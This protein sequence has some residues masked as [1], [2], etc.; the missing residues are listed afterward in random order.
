MIL[1]VWRRR[2]IASSRSSEG[3]YL[4]FIDGL[5]TSNKLTINFNMSLEHRIL[6]THGNCISR[7]TLYPRG[8]AF[9]LINTILNDICIDRSAIN[10][11]TLPHFDHCAESRNSIAQCGGFLRREFLLECIRYEKNLAHNCKSI[12][13]GLCELVPI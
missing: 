3:T 2:A 5:S 12:P 7:D 11:E 6:R 9:K 13:F 10:L 8:I 4:N 1:T